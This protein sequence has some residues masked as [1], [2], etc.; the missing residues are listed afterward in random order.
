MLLFQSKRRFAGVTGRSQPL[1]QKMNNSA[2][3]IDYFS[4]L[5]RAPL[6]EMR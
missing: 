6:F 4:R 3:D 2:R 1:L 5:L